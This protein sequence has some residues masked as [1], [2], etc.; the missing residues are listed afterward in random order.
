[1]YN[2]INVNPAYAGTRETFNAFV[3]HRNQWVGLD[4]AP[5]TNTASIN[6]NVGDSKFGVGLSFVNDNIGPTQEN[7][8]SADIAYII[9]LNGEYKLSFGIKGTANLYSLDVN[10]LTIFQKEDPE[11]QSLNGKLS[12]NIGTGVYFYSDKFYVGA[13]VPNFNK[14]KYYNANEVSI[15]TKSVNYYLLSGYVF[16]LSQSVKFKPSFL[17]K[18]DEG[19]PLQLDVNANFM[20]NDKFV[21]GGSYR[22]ESAVSLLAGFQFSNS[23]FLGYGY[24]LETTKLSNYN[25]GSHEIFLRY[26]F[27]K[28][29]R[30]STPRFF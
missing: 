1:M 13:S 12:P 7:A 11:F 2:T 5:V 17:A 19:A 25:S 4:G 23:W 29:T 16:D 24:D 21:L 28:N 6:T 3:L 30:I 27:F 9:P 8:I 26:E 14:T 20:F 22:L 10:K 15:N 18:I